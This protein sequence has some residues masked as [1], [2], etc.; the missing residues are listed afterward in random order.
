MDAVDKMVNIKDTFCQYMLGHDT[1][2]NDEVVHDVNGDRICTGGRDNIWSTWNT[3][4][5][6]VPFTSDSMHK[7][8]KLYSVRNNVNVTHVN[9]YI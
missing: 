3:C 1:W 8:N 4:S 7:Y 5:T 9:I 2:N 6:E